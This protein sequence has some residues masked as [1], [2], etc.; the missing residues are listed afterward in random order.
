MRHLFVLLG[1]PGVGKGTVA[2]GL[3]AE[4]MLQTL[5]SGRL[6]RDMRAAATEVGRQI[7]KLID[8]GKF[9][10]DEL[11]IRMVGEK[12]ETYPRDCLLMLDGFPRTLPQAEALDEI[13]RRSDDNLSMVL[14]IQA[15]DAE[16]E[17]RVL[18]RAREEGRVDD[19]LE[20]FRHRLSVFHDQTIPLID[21][22]REQNKIVVV[23][24]MG[25]PSKVMKQA[26]LLIQQSL[27]N[28][29]LLRRKEAG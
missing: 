5:S 24:G 11:I 28:G 10:P 23:D 6:L 9:A 12:L 7:T 4:F 19:T 18:K 14:E 15:D 16:L 3:V 27:P 2:K 8:Q 1:P 17:R 21:Y 13:I 26:K 25:T 20:T 29:E 22:Y